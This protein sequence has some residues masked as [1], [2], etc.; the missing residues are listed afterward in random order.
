MANVVA[1]LLVPSAAAD[2]EHRLLGVGQHVP[3]ARHVR[4]AGMGLNRCEARGI[5]CIG[6]ALAGVL[7]CALVMR[8]HGDLSQLA[9]ADVPQPTIAT[10]DQV[11]GLAEELT[12]QGA[13][14]QL[15]AYGNTM[16]A[17]TNPEANDPGFGTV[18]NGNADRRSWTAMSNFLEEIFTP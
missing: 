6:L 4:R 3:Q 8:G 14:W 9:L 16:H 10:P 17:F 15:H 1:R 2:D 7:M 12:G 13:D 11:L 5:D 18:Y